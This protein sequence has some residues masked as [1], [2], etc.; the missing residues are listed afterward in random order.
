MIVNNYILNIF[1]S[2]S[3]FSECFT[4]NKKQCDLQCLWEKKVILWSSHAPYHTTLTADTKG[5]RQ[6]ENLSVRINL[7]GVCWK[8]AR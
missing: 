1:H 5:E 8:E 2:C 4:M 6:R 7:G 3:Y